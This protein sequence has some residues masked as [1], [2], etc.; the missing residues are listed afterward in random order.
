[1]VILDGWAPCMVACHLC[2]REFGAASIDLHVEQCLKKWEDIE[3]QKPRHKR[4]PA[5]E[6][7]SLAPDMTQEEFNEAVRARFVQSGPSLEP[8]L[9]PSVCP[10]EHN[11]R[12]EFASHNQMG[13]DGHDLSRSGPSWA[14]CQSCG[15]LVP[16]EN[17]QEHLDVCG[18]EIGS[19]PRSAPKPKTITCHIC[20]GEFG[21]KSVELHRQRCAELWKA[22]GV[23]EGRIASP[24]DRVR[25][26][27]SFKEMCPETTRVR[28]SSPKA[29]RPLTTAC[30]LCKK[31]FSFASIEIHTR[32]R[33]KL[34]Q[35]RQGPG[36]PRSKS[37]GSRHVKWA[38]QSMRSL[39]A[40]EKIRSPRTEDCR[41]CGKKFLTTSLH[42]HERRC[43]MKGN[44]DTRKKGRPSEPPRQRS[45][46]KKPQSSIDIRSTTCDICGGLFSNSSIGIHQRQCAKLL[47]ARQAKSPP[48]ERDILEGDT[49]ENIDKKVSEPP[50]MVVC[51]ICGG[52]FGKASIGIHVPQCRRK[53]EECEQHKPPEERREPP[54]DPPDLAQVSLGEYN[55][56]AAAIYKEGRLVMCS[57]CG[58]QFQED[59]AESHRQKCEADHTEA[60][61]A[62]KPILVVCHICGR[63][64]GTSSI[65]KHLPSCSKKWEDRESKQPADQQRP[66]PQ[67]PMR[68]ADMSQEDFN[69]A[70]LEVFSDACLKS[71]QYCGR[72][73]EEDNLGEHL[74]ICEQFAEQPS[75][76]AVASSPT[77][78]FRIKKHP[79]FDQMCHICGKLYG[80]ASIEIHIQQC[81][82]KWENRQAR[83]PIDKR[84]DVPQRPDGTQDISPPVHDSDSDDPSAALLLIKCLKCGSSCKSNDFHTH[85]CHTS[86]DEHEAKAPDD[87]EDN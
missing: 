85:A 26:T 41:F 47:A 40:D 76:P 4:K 24:E 18:S 48:F 9:L 84:R 1:M 75:Q 42:M 30:S 32:Q 5:P 7:P 79:Y 43:L 52:F 51:H 62:A 57:R 81:T 38:S 56:A 74:R 46:E 83:K 35:R 39:S 27:A 60:L 14:R 58:G 20:G 65:A 34:Y 86:G 66:I 61:V 2:G 25:K 82:L 21:S 63:E 45:R 28:S 68:T 16:P 13:L 78:P 50:E 8:R 59:Q 80:K 72:K 64:F 67:A 73:F 11:V 3:K 49:A 69:K 71:C 87:K 15:R 44:A 37:C 36:S 17:L 33:A 12:L 10:L 29:T 22:R 23:M 6:C 54:K 19:S 31:E 55:A 53:W 77:S 70:A